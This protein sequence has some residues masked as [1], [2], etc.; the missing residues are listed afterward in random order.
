MPPPDKHRTCSREDCP[1]INVNAKSTVKC[2]NCDGT[3]HLPCYDIIQ[4]PDRI[5]VTKNIVFICD[6]CLLLG[7]NSPKRKSIQSTL[8]TSAA[9]ELLL[10]RSQP[11]SSQS[12]LKNT[13][14]SISNLVMKIDQQNATLIKLE[15]SVVSMH[16]TI[17]E[18]KKT[19]NATIEKNNAALSENKKVI[20]YAS[21]VGKSSQPQ[22]LTTSAQN[23]TTNSTSSTS[24]NAKKTQVIDAAQKLA[25]KNRR[26][27]SGTNN[28]SEHGLGKA[29]P[30]AVKRAPIEK[31]KRVILPKSIYL[32]RL[33][34]SVKSEDIVNYIKQN[35]SEFNDS[36]ISLRMLVKKDQS[37]DDFTFI[38]Y[39]L[40]CTLDLFDKLMSA[41]FWP[42]HVMIGEFIEKPPEKRN[43]LSDFVAEKINVLTG[44]NT[45]NESTHETSN[46]E[47]SATPKN[48]SEKPSTSAEVGE[49]DA[50]NNKQMNTS[51]TPSDPS[52]VTH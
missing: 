39:R 17:T 42:E 47:S 10:N 6:E 32:S 34:T 22:K 20:S 21:V 12:K 49:T 15:K 23:A 13:N 8:S 48:D 35:V 38:S 46:V 33:E 4:S 1:T 44:K 26:L 3:C 7:P 50:V 43:Q 18:Q 31:P 27:L 29:V 16:S 9:G 36:H 19:M 30:I 52:Q 14:E 51:K 5:F 24:T 2:F 41:D 37:L 40:S 45:N 25:F 28:V 11:V